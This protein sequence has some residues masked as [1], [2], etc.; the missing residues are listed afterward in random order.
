MI[1]VLYGSEDSHYDYINVK[2]HA[3]SDDYGKDLI[4]AGVS[5]IMFGLMNAIDMVDSDANISMKENEITIEL[6]HTSDKTDN[7]LELA[8]LQLKTIEESYSQY[9]KIDER[10]KHK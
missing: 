8:I 7:Y 6:S 5:S 1:R 2:G 3:M 10:R 4:C 9:I